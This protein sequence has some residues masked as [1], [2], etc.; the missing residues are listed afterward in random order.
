MGQRHQIFIRALNPLYKNKPKEAENVENLIAYKKLHKQ[1][2]ARKH[3]ILAF[4][5]Q[6]LYGLTAIGNLLQVL[7]FNK[8]AKENYCNPFKKDYITYHCRFLPDIKENW[9][10]VIKAIM[11]IQTNEISESVGRFGVEKFHYLNDDE[12]YMR[13]HF[14]W[15]DNNDG[16]TI[17]DTV[18]GKYCFISFCG[19]EGKN[20]LP[21]YLP[22][23]AQD[24]FKTYYPCYEEEQMP[25][26][27]AEMCYNKGYS[28]NEIIK[29]I[30]ERKETLNLFNEKFK[31]YPVLTLDE[32][33]SIFPKVYKEV[34][35]EKIGII[36]ER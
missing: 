6:W 33:K 1:L 35:P 36:P 22:V 32:V 10:D 9:I 18:T 16:C 17:I 25:S 12:P 5:N 29:E 28:L 15:G 2:G 11:E 7:E 13:H 24:Y 3:T 30:P 34:E 26:D 31:E 19:T 4:H 27:F 23:S 20:G 8:K 21:L 14:D